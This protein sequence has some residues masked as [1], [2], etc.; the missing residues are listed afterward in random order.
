MSKTDKTII[1]IA[2]LVM[3]ILTIST[4]LIS[5]SNKFSNSQT[6]QEI[7]EVCIQESCFKVELAETPEERA[8]GLMNRTFLAGDNGMLFIFPK[9]GYYGFWMK[10]TLI[11][12]DIIWINENLEIVDIVTAQPCGEVC[13]AYKPDE[14]AEYVLEINAGMASKLRIIKKEKIKIK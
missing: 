7:S 9:S 6:N 1:I 4:L 14:K 12:L 10:N 3:I 8:I 11:P 13:H 5:H 2:L